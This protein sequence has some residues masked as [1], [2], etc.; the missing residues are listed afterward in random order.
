MENE[1]NQEV[2]VEETQST[3]INQPEVKADEPTSVTVCAN[4]ENS[5]RDCV[6]CSDKTVV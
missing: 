5:G 2:P 3:T 1:P 6:V 4:C